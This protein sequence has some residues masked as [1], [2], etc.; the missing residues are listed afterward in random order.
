MIINDFQPF[1][2]QHCET[3]ATGSHLKQ[4]GIGKKNNGKT[5]GCHQVITRHLE[6]E[7]QARASD[8]RIT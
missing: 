2:E 5:K 8:N 6:H 4:T 3:T 1:V 7:L